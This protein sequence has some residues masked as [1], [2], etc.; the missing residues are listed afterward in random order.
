MPGKHVCRSV[1]KAVEVQH[2]SFSRRNFLWRFGGGLGGIALAQL[3]AENGLLGAQTV[4]N[5]PHHLP[6]ARRVVQLFMSGAASQCDMFDYK[7]ELI[8]RHGQKFDPGGKVELFQSD[9]GPCMKSPWEWQPS[10]QCGKWMSG[11]VPHLASCVDDIAFIHS[12]VSKSNIHGPATYMQ[13]SGFVLPGFPNMGAWISYALG[14]LNENLPTFVVLPDVRGFAPNGP[15]NWSAGFLPGQHQGTMLRIGKPNPIY[16]L[17]PPPSATYI[18]PESER[19]GRALLH[20]FNRQHAA[21]REGDSRLDARIASFEMAARLQLSA[22]EVLDISGESAATKKLYGLDREITQDFGSRCLIAR[23]LLERGV[24]FVQVWSGA[25]N[26]F[27]RRNWDSHENLEKD[28]GEMGTSMDKPA[29][30]LI[31]DLKARGLLDETIVLWTTEFGRM[32][33]TQ[34]GKGRDHNPFAFTNWLAGGGVKGG[35]TFGQSDEWSYKVAEH[36]TYCYDIHATIL[37]LLGLDHTKL[38]FRH[39]GIDRRLTDVHGEIIESI[40]A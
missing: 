30:A 14:S 18:T 4:R 19:D 26:G 2:S 11:L 9:P 35:V 10:G 24:R 1:Q 5:N 13:N 7:P 17:F 6:K 33:C 3:L 29:A 37:H 38:T 12:M 22:P 28:H 34:G 31:K 36:P 21:E 32:P 15:A 16:D 23:R 40:I 39:N 27:P 20:E 8:Q 25:D